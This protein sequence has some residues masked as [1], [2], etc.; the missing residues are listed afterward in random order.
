MYR[1]WL[2]IMCFWGFY[3]VRGIKNKNLSKVAFVITVPFVAFLLFTKDFVLNKSSAVI[4]FE[5]TR[6]AL[7]WY[8]LWFL[9][10][11][12]NLVCFVAS[13]TLLFRRPYPV[14]D[15]RSFVFRA[16][17]FITICVTY[18]HIFVFYPA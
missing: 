17:A 2:I 9:L 15:W 6:Q 1:A 7:L 18:V 14:E 10:L 5:E 16:F 13:F 4:G 12:G 11:F 3:V 8:D